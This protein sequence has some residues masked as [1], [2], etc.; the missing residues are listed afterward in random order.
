[1]PFS[2]FFFSLSIPRSGENFFSEWRS[3]F[4]YQLSVISYHFIAQIQRK[5]PFCEAPKRN[6]QSR[7]SAFCGATQKIGK[8]FMVQFN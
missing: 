1:M 2:L 3:F 6:S 4:S 7:E 8:K 5:K